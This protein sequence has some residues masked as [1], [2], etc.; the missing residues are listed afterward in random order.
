MHFLTRH[1]AA[2][3][4]LS[5]LMSLSAGC[6]DPT[7]LPE[8]KTGSLVVSQVLYRASDDSLEWLEIR[9]DGQGAA[10]LAGV[11][12]SAV[13]YQFPSTTPTLA[14]GA[15]L[16]LTNDESLFA[17]HHPGVRIGGVF[18]GRLSNDG[19]EIQ[20]D[21]AEG[22]D[23]KFSYGP[24]EPWPAAA[25]VVGS[26]LV[27]KGGDPELPG[28]WAA[29]STQG[30]HP[31]AASPTATDKGIWISEVRPAD[32]SGNGFVELASASSESVD[33]SG[34]IVANAMGSVKSDTLPAG[35]TIAAH[36]RLVLRQTTTDQGTGWGALFP[37]A[38][39]DELV[40]VERNANGSVTGNVHTLAWSAIPDGMSFGRVG[41]I[42]S[43]AGEA[44]VATPTP[45]AADETRRVGLVTITEVCFQPD[46][47]DAEFVE[48][49]NETDSV[50]HLG[51]AADTSRS[52]SLTGT[53]KTFLS[54]DTLAPRGKMVLVAKSDMT[55][56]GFR[57]KWNIPSS[58]PVVSFSGKLD[59]SG[60]LLQ[61][62]HPSIATANGS[63]GISWKS[64]VEDDATWSPA[65]PW[66]TLAAGGG[67]CLERRTRTLPGTSVFAWTAA[68]PTPGI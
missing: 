52:W 24:R 57:S 15:R 4:A 32:I 22:K 53:G 51:F 47:A 33:L 67:A 37:A 27:Y 25:A 31:G 14:P 62:K 59:N 3:W 66:P 18:T 48:I 23:F 38:I 26:A 60:E 12:I 8:A 61:L 68:Q 56:D 11:K 64:V 58:V 13:G 10:V 50:I 17:K 49:Q 45:G 46:S 39:S 21:G 30:G 6:S 65:S 40:L 19:E 29:S 7:T 5:I 63:G 41:T 43:G 35:T 36:G 54:S 55:V 20:L 1:T 9:N 28:S 44:L 16:V 34:W 2:L 42:G